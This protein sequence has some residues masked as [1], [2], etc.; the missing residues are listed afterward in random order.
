MIT[1]AGLEQPPQRF[2]AG[3]DAIALAEQKAKDLQAQAGSAFHDL[4]TSLDLDNRE[5]K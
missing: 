1:I 5:S 2:I 3:A 4:S